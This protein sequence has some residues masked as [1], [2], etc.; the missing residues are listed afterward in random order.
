MAGSVSGKLEL[1]LG[2]G[3]LALIGRFDSVLILVLSCVIC[4]F[5]E[6]YC[7][8]LRYYLQCGGIRDGYYPRS[9]LLLL[10]ISDPGS[11]NSN[12]G[13]E[14]IVVLRFFVASKFKNY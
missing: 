2:F 12:K 9:L 3:S 11:N 8:F 13:R 4:F 5:P 1:I 14:K 6:A 7:S 10:S